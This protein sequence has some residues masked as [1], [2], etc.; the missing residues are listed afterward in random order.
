VTRQ[1]RN[2]LPL[3]SIVSL[4]GI[5]KA[6]NLLQGDQLLKKVYKGTHEINLHSS[7]DTLF[8]IM[9]AGIAR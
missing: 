8:V 4:L 2:V 3:V 7:I 1:E 6:S 5:S 9:I